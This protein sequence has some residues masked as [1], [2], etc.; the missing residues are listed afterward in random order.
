MTMSSPRE[1]ERDFAAALLGGSDQAIV[2]EIHGDGLDPAARVAIYRHHVFATLTEALEAT[3]PVVVRLVDRRFFGYA[4]DRFI[5]EH[6]P[7]GPCLFEYGE[8]LAD[9]LATFPPCRHLPYLPDVA[10]LEWALSCALHAEDAVPLDP[11]WLAAI[12]PEEVRRLKLRLHPSTSLIQ[13][14]WPIDRIWRANQPGAD[15]DATVSLEGGGACLQ[16][17]RL[18]DDPMFRRLEP[19]GYAFR[20]ALASDLDLESAAAAARAA[21]PTFDLTDALRQLL[22]DGLIVGAIARPVQHR[23]GAAGEPRPPAARTTPSPTNGGSRCQ[24]TPHP[25]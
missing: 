4:A 9:F 8:S 14:P 11:R 13:S 6:P 23:A 16:V 18:E 17:Y 10:R 20:R 22:D 3:Y 2:A 5:R 7:A 21:E 1:L 24:P 19:G 15:P 25:G 12:P